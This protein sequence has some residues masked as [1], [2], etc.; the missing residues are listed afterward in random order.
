[1]AEWD[2]GCGGGGVFSGVVGGGKGV[3]GSGGGIE[4]GEG[5]VEVFLFLKKIK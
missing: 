4:E 3:V 2:W 1:M 5:S